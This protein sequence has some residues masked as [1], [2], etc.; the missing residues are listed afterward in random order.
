MKDP[1]KKSKQSFIK[2][3]KNLLSETTKR[4]NELK[5]DNESLNRVINFQD[6]S[7]NREISEIT[8]A[9]KEKLI[10]TRFELENMVSKV[11]NEKNL[12]REVLERKIQGEKSKLERYV[13]I[14]EIEK[15]GLIEKFDLMQHSLKE[16]AERWEKAFKDLESEKASKDKKN[17]QVKVYLT[18][19]EKKV[20]EDLAKENNSDNSSVMR[21]LLRTKGNPNLGYRKPIGLF[22]D[23]ATT[24]LMILN[25]NTFDDISEYISFL[26]DGKA[27]IVN[28]DNIEN[29]EKN[30]LQRCTDFIS[31]A[32][33]K[34]KSEIVVLG[35]SLI[36]VTTS[37]SKI[38]LIKEEKNQ[39][40]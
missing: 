35:K 27:I 12:M 5:E 19:S 38:K 29:S 26:D 36:L 20:L 10:K 31:G 3:L 37:K 17:A 14:Q 1:D 7:L 24:S 40:N 30:I 25:P 18:E 33:Y 6:A 32:T 4:E 21:D 22:W 11:Q 2:E 23:A 28:L 34:S 16:K 9:Y 13:A 15:R 8:D 39:E